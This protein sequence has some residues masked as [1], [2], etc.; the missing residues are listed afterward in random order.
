MTG[1][2]FRAVRERYGW[3]AAQV[4]RAL[5]YNRTAVYEWETGRKRLPAAVAAWART[6]P[7]IPPARAWPPATR[8]GFRWW[9][10]RHGM[11]CREVAEFCGVA[12]HTVCRWLTGASPLPLGIRAWL[13]A[14]A[15]PLWHWAPPGSG[16][17]CLALRGK[18]AGTPSRL[19]PQPQRRL[20]SHT[21]RR[22]RQQA[23]P[24]PRRR[25]QEEIA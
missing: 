20:G 22:L 21:A 25:R 14:G 16:P 18:P 3:S 24:R 9:Y 1:A 2:E 23:Q 12:E 6:L 5:H 13:Q 7:P 8:G 4:A 15:P 19:R 17:N 11:T 10:L